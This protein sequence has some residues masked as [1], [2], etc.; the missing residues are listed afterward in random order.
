M[1]EAEA[2]VREWFQCVWNDGDASAIDRLLAP[3]CAVHGLPTPDGRPI[4]G[5][6]EFKEFHRNLRSAFPDI[7]IVILQ[8]VA[9]ENRCA[10]R[11]EVTGTHSGEGLGIP[12][13]GRRISYSGMG[14]AEV[15]QGR[16]RQ[17][18]NH[19]DFALMNRQLGLG[20]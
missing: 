5:I 7:R 2:V 1:T 4:T 11:C 3:R 12:A 19:F 8:S 20:V 6:E 9:Q 10:V 13:T 15:E 14:L 17:A 16:I 18:W